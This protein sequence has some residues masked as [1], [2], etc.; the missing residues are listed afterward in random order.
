[1]N[2]IESEEYDYYYMNYL[3]LFG[4]T[5]SKDKIESIVSKAIAGRRQA[6]KQYEQRLKR[7]FDDFEKK[8]TQVPGAYL[9]GWDVDEIERLR[10]RFGGIILAFFHYGP[11]RNILT[12]LACQGVKVVAP[13]AGNAYWDYYSLRQKGPEN[14]GESIQLIN[15]EKASVGKQLIRSIRS[16]RIA[17]IYVDGNMG[18]THS[19]REDGTVKISFMKK[20]INVKAGV[21][22]IA[23]LN[24]YPILPI[25][26]IAQDDKG[27]RNDHVDYGDLI[28]SHI[29]VKDDARQSK[30]TI[31]KT[32]IESLY[33][34][35]ETRVMSKPQHWEY[36]LCLHRWL[37]EEKVVDS[38]KNEKKELETLLERG[39][40]LKTD[41]ERVS[42]LL[43]NGVTCL[44]DTKNN[45]GYMPPSWCMELFKYL[46]DGVGI[47]LLWMESQQFSTDKV[48]AVKVI[49]AQMW[50]KQ[51]LKTHRL[52]LS[53]NS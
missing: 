32:V 40:V 13:I 47:G 15:V 33:S 37:S 4:G 5:L 3:S 24:Q 30:E 23:M 14:F 50:E 20:S 21:A 45:K 17:G 31:I 44:I 41:N 38:S 8:P 36:A 26:A 42:S 19:E 27:V 12:D 7:M 43:Q 11:H 18:P 46:E 51:L 34:Q 16:G 22:R 39:F 29:G 1:M 53:K 6:K 52:S 25:F 28:T 10:S 48:E 2:T 9:T 35:L 49:L